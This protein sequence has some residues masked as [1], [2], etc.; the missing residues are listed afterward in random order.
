MAD[1]FISYS[2]KD[3]DFVRAL[4]D[5]LKKRNRDTW[6]DWEGIPPTAKWL[7]EIYDGI[8]KADTFVFVISPDSVAS[9][10]CQK[11]IA[12]AA[13]HNKR[14]VPIVRREVG[15]K[16]VPPPLGDYQWIFFGAD[17]DFELKFQELLHALD[18]DLK[19]AHT[20]T[21]L[22]V[23]AIEWENKK[24][25][26]AYLLRGNDLQEAEEWQA[27]AASG[28]EP[29]PTP[30]QSEFVLA[31]RQSSARRQ[32]LVLFG[33]SAAL[34]ITFIL[35]IAAL[36]QRNEAMFQASVAQTA[37]AK[38]VTERNIAQSRELAASAISKSAIDPELSLL[39]ALEATKVSKTAQSEDALRQLLHGPNLRLIMRGHTDSVN[40]AS[41]STDEKLVISGSRDGTA[42]IWEA[43][44]GKSVVELIGHTASVNSAE[45]NPD[46]MLVVTGSDDGTIRLW[47][48]I[49]GKNVAILRGDTLP[50]RRAV[51]S[52]S[53]RYILSTSDDGTVRIWDTVT[54]KEIMNMPGKN[55][56][57]YA[58]VF[59]PDSEFV[60]TAGL[61]W[62]MWH[63]ST[64][65]KIHEQPLP[66]TRLASFSQDE[67]LLGVVRLYGRD[68]TDVFIFRSALGDI[69]THVQLTGASVVNIV[70]SPD[71]K[72][73]L[74]AS[75]DGVVRV[76]TTA[77]G[78]IVSELHG[79]TQSI[80][81][82]SFS[83]DGRLVVTS[84][85]D[86]TARVWE[87]SSGKNI[88][89]F[90]VDNWVNAAK[91]N[92][93]GNEVLTS[94]R[95]GTVRIWRVAANEAVVELNNFINS[96]SATKFS[97][98][99]KLVMT[100]GLDRY[101]WA[102]G[103]DATS[104][105]R[106]FGRRG[107]FTYS[108]EYSVF[109][110]KGLSVFSHDGKVAI[111]SDSVDYGV[112]VWDAATGKILTTLR[113]HRDTVNSAE[114]SPDGRY[115]VT[116]CHD[117]TARVWDVATGKTIAELRGNAESVTDASFSPDGRFVITL[118]WNLQA[119]IWETISGKLITEL[120]DVTDLAFSPDSKNVF[121]RSI[122]GTAKVWKLENGR[123]V[124]QL[125]D[126]LGSL[127]FAK[128]SPD[129][130]IIATKTKPSSP[131]YIKP[132]GLIDYEWLIW[133][134]ASGKQITE[135]SGHEDSITSV[136]FSLSGN[137][138]LTSS[139]DKTARVWNTMTGDHLAIFRGHSGVVWSSEFSP[140]G[141]L[142][143]T[144][145]SDNTAR[146]WEISTGKSIAELR[147]HTRSVTNA[148][149]SPDG[150]SI[151][152]SSG[153]GTARIF[154][155]G[156]F[157]PLEDLITI[158]QMKVTRDLTCEERL[159]YLH[160]NVTCP[161]PTPYPTLTQSRTPT[162]KP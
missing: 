53:G 75:E 82:S 9:E 38:A 69:I 80:T 23:H 31:S 114:F 138:I 105:K 73:F 144:A 159:T 86:G 94:N 110:G 74:T 39:L 131:K 8:E 37:E 139:I 58:A 102:Q 64:G 160:E 40:I 140:D 6:V 109:R 145:S 119:R 5:A 52:P 11:E 147:G 48:A 51:F 107:L 134:V 87:T 68:T 106:T 133:N 44:T 152:T 142:V 30:L 12:H 95:D 150:K 130:N 97:S 155:R 78:E 57:I 148:T 66:T 141:K 61:S 4:H 42:R 16:D 21:R 113:G 22:L 149:F 123:T 116:A 151:I 72:Y 20:H 154:P 63:I 124:S 126:P 65:E 111:P 96:A 132:S 115:I 15:P 1:V 27:Q 128:F 92:E 13:K 71:N 56:K 99:N 10:T 85:Y 70:F 33:V 101:Y 77:K 41:F 19:W 135:V 46:G 45:F 127:V 129:G 89:V 43:S 100:V 18:S 79:H 122:D 112:D 157:A 120:R 88:A 67:E 162:P 91:F 26:D 25:N 83:Q 104:G 49:T 90:R 81:S 62:T 50:V 153:D 117:G 121:T 3:R 118:T 55:T 125:G 146:V 17:D 93:S 137:L 76:W 24:R 36:F 98:D 14:I 32:R 28:K 7:A 158:A 156:M 47:E 84:S 59:S 161:T 143:V 29:K 136:D 108:S 2:R 54:S 103:Y 60:L 34:V 35:A